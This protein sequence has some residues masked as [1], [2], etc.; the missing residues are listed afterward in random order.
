MDRLLV[1]HTIPIKIRPED[2]ITLDRL[3]RYTFIAALTLYK[4]TPSLVNWP[5]QPREVG[6]RYMR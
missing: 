5:L 3:E 1:A 4:T 6:L 2:R